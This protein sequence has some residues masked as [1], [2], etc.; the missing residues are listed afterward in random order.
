MASI[1]D[2]M[3]PAE[4]IESLEKNLTD[5]LDDLLVANKI[6]EPRKVRIKGGRPG[7]TGF[8]VVV[9]EKP[10]VN[11]RMDMYPNETEEPH[12]KVTYQGQTCRFRVADCTPMKAEAQNGIPNQIK[13]IMKEIKT[14][15]QK[16]KEQIIQVWLDSRPTN[17]NH[18]HQHIR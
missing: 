4:K 2:L 14:V 3:T 5:S 18:G 10:R 16:N 12:F 8:M 13:K 15:W 1:E 9:K 6:E 11:F 17:Q 7:Y